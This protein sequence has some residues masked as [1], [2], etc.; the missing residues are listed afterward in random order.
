[1]CSVLLL[2]DALGLDPCQLA[3]GPNYSGLT[4]N[5]INCNLTSFDFLHHAFI[6]M[7]APVVIPSST[8]VDALDALNGL[9][10]GLHWC[11]GRPHLQS[12]PTLQ[13]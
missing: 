5:I 1:M 2:S 6:H 3:R 4:V 8:K 11:H 13:W 12:Q 7:L 9:L 10:S